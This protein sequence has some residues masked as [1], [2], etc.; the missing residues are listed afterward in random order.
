MPTAHRPLT[1]ADLVRHGPLRRLGAGVL[2]FRSVE[3]TNSLLLRLAEELGDGVIALAEHQSAGRGRLGREWTAPR[4]AAILLSA[5]LVEPGRSRLHVLAG[6][7]AAVAT[8][9]AVAAATECRPCVR[10]PND[11]VFGGRKLGGV[12]VETRPL[13]RGGQHALVIGIGLN[14]LQQR[15]HFRGP[16]AERATSLEIESAGAVDRAAVASGLVNRLDYWVVQAADASAG[17]AALR[18]AWHGLCGDFGARA[19]LDHDGEVY[20][21][22][23]LDVDRQG[24]LVVQLDAGGRRHFPAATTRRLWGE[25]AGT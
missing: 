17:R 9:E 16:L 13:A 25:A 12:L 14:C 23:I 4:G 22:T 8:C 11:V 19:A 10:W 2:T 1:C 3:S 21:G 24:D 7:A 5:L 15:G 20:T 18:A 6:L